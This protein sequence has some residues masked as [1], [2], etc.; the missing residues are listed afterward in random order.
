MKA[1]MAHYFLLACL[2][3]CSGFGGLR[4]DGVCLPGWQQAALPMNTLK[5]LPVF[6][7]Q[8]FLRLLP[9]YSQNKKSNP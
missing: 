6:Q 4:A 5:N 1:Y 9:E 8:Q 2:L 7:Q 3:C